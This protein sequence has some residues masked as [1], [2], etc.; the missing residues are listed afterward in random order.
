MAS[1]L[2]VAAGNP[3]NTMEAMAAQLGNGILLCR[4]NQIDADQ[5]RSGGFIQPKMMYE[6]RRGK[7]TRRLTGGIV[8]FSTK[9]FWKDLVAMGDESTR[10]YY[11][12][13]GYRE[14]MSLLP[15][16]APAAQLRRLAVIQSG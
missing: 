14:A 15:V 1:Q 3:G 16:T 9:D 13:Y 10:Q 5:Q 12:N 4:A 8:Q 11:E 7:M 2:T 6:V